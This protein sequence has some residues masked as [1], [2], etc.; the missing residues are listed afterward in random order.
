EA[1]DVLSIAAL[2]KIAIVSLHEKAAQAAAIMLR[3]RTKADVFVVSELA[4]GSGTKN[5]RTADVVLLVWAATKHAVYRAFD[6]M[7]DKIAYVQGTGAS[8]IV[9]SLERWV[10][11]SRV[12]LV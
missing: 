2:Q 11:N 8:S 9:L 12:T 10:M 6:D 1:E 3:E 5:A 7:R 4:A